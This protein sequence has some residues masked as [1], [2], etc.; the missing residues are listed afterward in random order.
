M[1]TTLVSR[2]TGVAAVV[3]GL[4]LAAASV[5]ES[6]LPIGCVGAQCDLRP[7]R[8]VSPTADAFY[9]VALALLVVAAGGLGLLLLRRR[10]LGRAGVVAVSLIAAGAVVVVG[11]NVV[12]SLFFDGDLSAMPALLLPAVGAVVLGFAVLMVVVIRARLVPLWAGVLVGLAVLV[13]PFG[14]QENTT[15]LLD[16]P[17]GLALALAGALLLRAED[18]TPARNPDDRVTVQGA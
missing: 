4:S 5:V 7:Q 2:V 14:D 15:V 17:F 10:R 13:L 9:V 18:P 12:Q 16:V 8:P 6:R 1:H 11:A 3:A